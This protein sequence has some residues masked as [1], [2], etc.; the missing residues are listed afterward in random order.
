MATTQ[1]SPRV[2][3]KNILFTTDFSAYAEAALPY[4]HAL[5]QRYGSK[6]FVT[7]VVPS[8][9]RLSVP[10]DVLPTAIDLE[11]QRAERKMGAIGSSAWLKDIEHRQILRQGELWYVLSS[12]IAQESID[13]VVTATHGREGLKKLVLGSSAERIFRAALCPVLTV[14]PKAAARDVQFEN[15]KTIVLTTD[16][17]PASVHALPYALSIAQE[18]QAQ[19][20]LV[21]VVT[22]VPYQHRETVIESETARLKALLTEEETAW[23]QPE[24][25][26]NFQFPAEGILDAA[27]SHHA[28]MIVMGV[29]HGDTPRLASHLP[30]TTAYDVVCGASCPVLT[31]RE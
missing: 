25:V 2:S 13:L 17:S 28:D 15:L 19:L 29:R 31:V 22:M 4:V 7:H 20:I 30:W 6:V 8:E 26:V 14:G 11:W 10:L 16:F 9:A 18:N 21:H 12:I 23:C 5:S 3:L 24:Y 1:A 27:S